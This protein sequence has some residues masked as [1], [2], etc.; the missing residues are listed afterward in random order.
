[1]TKEEAK[2]VWAETGFNENDFYFWWSCYLAKHPN[3][4][5]WIKTDALLP[6]QEILVICRPFGGDRSFVRGWTNVKSGSDSLVSQVDF[7]EWVECWK[8][9]P[10]IAEK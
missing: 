7:I 2:A 6:P 1:M 8:R 4:N 10:P 3:G 5:E 9:I